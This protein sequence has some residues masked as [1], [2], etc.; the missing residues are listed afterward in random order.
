MQSVL[1]R[2]SGESETYGTAAG[3]GFGLLVHATLEWLGV[4]SE[5]MSV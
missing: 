1:A 2:S 5:P 3:G 4:S